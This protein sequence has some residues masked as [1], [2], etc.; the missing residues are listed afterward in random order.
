MFIALFSCRVLPW[1][2]FV[3]VCMTLCSVYIWILSMFN[4]QTKYSFFCTACIIMV[5]ISSRYI[6]VDFILTLYKWMKYCYKLE[7]I[8]APIWHPVIPIFIVN[9]WQTQLSGFYCKFN[10]ILYCIYYV[11]GILKVKLK[12]QRKKMDI[13]IYNLFCT[14]LTKKMN[15]STTHTPV[16]KSHGY[17][18]SQKVKVQNDFTNLYE[19]LCVTTWSFLVILVWNEVKVWRHSLFFFYTHIE[20]NV[21]SQRV[22]SLTKHLEGRL[23]WQCWRKD[24][25]T[26][27]RPGRG[28]LGPPPPLTH[29]WRGLGTPHRRSDGKP[30]SPAF[31]G[32][33]GDR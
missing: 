15:S 27:Q 7:N 22:Q 33:D 32:K 5:V 28:Q 11:D 21:L 29:R 10:R 23:K 31:K 17:E 8:Q 6:E 24:P 12:T 3:F 25:G 4:A 13:Y 26:G 2:C 1:W 20:Q 14:G 19:D 18:M 9:F 16:L 30:Q